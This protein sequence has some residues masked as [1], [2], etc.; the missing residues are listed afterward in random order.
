V[1]PGPP[2][3]VIAYAA[4]QSV[5][6][7]WT[8]PTEDGGAPITSYTAT[9]SPGGATCV[10]TYPFCIF[11]GLTNGR[12]YVVTVRD[13]NG[14][15]NS[16]QRTFSNHVF[17]G[18]VPSTPTNLRAI[19]ARDGEFAW[20]KSSSPYGEAVLRYAINATGDGRTYH[21]VSTHLSCLLKALPIGGTFSVTVAALDV[22]GWSGPSATL[23]YGPTRSM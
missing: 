20:S 3:S 5:E 12:Q 2:A 16:A 7:T 8:P 23:V 10:N 22:T 14:T 6:L 18:A 4:L 1:A 11:N 9:I 21:C 15:A 13:T 19:R 17:A